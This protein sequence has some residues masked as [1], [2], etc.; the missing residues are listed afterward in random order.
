[1]NKERTQ[2]KS[3]HMMPLELYY[4]KYN[5]QNK[6]LPSASTV[7]PN[8]VKNNNNNNYHQHHHHALSPSSV[9]NYECSDPSQYQAMIITI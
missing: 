7:T 8:G 5:R 9:A 3:T 6:K 1:M 2:N 4:V